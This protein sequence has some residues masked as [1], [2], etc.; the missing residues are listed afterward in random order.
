M[1]TKRRQF[2]ASM[3]AAAMLPLIN[4][5]EVRMLK[6]KTYSFRLVYDFVFDIATGE[7]DMKATEITIDED[8]HHISLKEM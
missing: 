4:I 8:G 1:M 2:F 7:F 3:L 6:P 5:T